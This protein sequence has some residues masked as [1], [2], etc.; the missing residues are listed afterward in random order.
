LTYG[1]FMNGLK[2]AG[3]TLDRKQLAELAV[4]SPSGFGAIAA[5]AKAAAKFAGSAAAS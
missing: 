1:Q 2:N 5:Q 4:A 3:I